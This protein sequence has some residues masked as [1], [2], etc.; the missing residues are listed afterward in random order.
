MSEKR[1]LRISVP[2]KHRIEVS[3]WRG[4]D[5]IGLE[6]GDFNHWSGFIT[7]DQANALIDALRKAIANIG[8][9]VDGTKGGTT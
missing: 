3:Q 1:D 2:G 7:V 5:D 8:N 9:Q 4:D 6:T